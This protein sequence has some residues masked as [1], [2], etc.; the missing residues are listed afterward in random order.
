VTGRKQFAEWAVQQNFKIKGQ[1]L[2]KKSD[3]SFGIQISRTD[4]VDIQSISAVT[5]QL[6]K[7][8]KSLDGDYD[9]W[10]TFVIKD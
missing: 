1:E 9:G 8:A 5:L 2:S 6:R 4:K 7:K 3:M 10:E